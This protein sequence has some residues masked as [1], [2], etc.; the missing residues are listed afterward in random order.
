MVGES[1]A[2]SLILLPK[3]LVLLKGSTE[4]SLDTAGIWHSKKPSTPPDDFA[5]TEPGTAERNPCIVRL[6]QY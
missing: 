2:E 6:G 3:P 1:L 4:V 5:T